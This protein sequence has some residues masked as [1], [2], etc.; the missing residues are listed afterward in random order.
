MPSLSK[1]TILLLLTLCNNYLIS[2]NFIEV[3]SHLGVDHHFGQGYASGGISLVDFNNDGW[4]DITLGTEDGQPISFYTNNGNNSFSQ[5]GFNIP[6]SSHQRHLVWVD[7]DN[8]Q[9][10]DLFVCNHLKPNK[11]YINDG[12][13]NFS[14]QTSSSGIL[15][16]NDDTYMATFGDLDND[17]LLDLYISNHWHAD[18]RVYKNLGNNQFS[19]ISHLSGINNSGSLL[20]ATAFFDFD[21]DGDLDVYK[22]ND[23][24]FRNEMYRNEGNFLFTD[25]SG[26][27]GV[28]IQVDAMGAAIGDLDNDGFSDIY[29]ANSDRTQA[30]GNLLPGNNL[31]KN[32]FPDPF[33]NISNGSGTDYLAWCWGGSW[34]DFD[35][36]GFLDIYVSNSNNGSPNGNKKNVLFF[37]NGDATFTA[38]SSGHMSS[39]DDISYATGTIDLN[40][41]GL[42]DI[43]VMNHDTVKTKIWNNNISNSNNYLKLEL[44]GLQ[45]NHKGVGSWIEVYTP[46][47]THYRYTHCGIGFQSQE[48]YNNHIG[49]G[50]VTTIDSV[51]VRW[52]SGIVDR[53]PSPSINQSI[54]LI[55]GTYRVDSIP[56]GRNTQFPTDSLV[57]L[58]NSI[59]RNWMEILLEAI[60][61]DYARPTVHARNL[62]H[63]S[64]LMYDVWA[65]YQNTSWTYFLGK[66]IDGYTCPFAGLP[67]QST[68]NGEREM[69]ISFA[70]YRL[71]KHRFL[72]SPNAGIMNYHF[73]N[74]MSILGYNIHDTSLDYTSGNPAA[75]GNYIADQIILF[76]LQDGSNES[77]DYTNLYYSPVNDSMIIYNPGNPN[78]TDLNRWQ[79]LTLDSFVDQSGNLIPFDTPEFLSPEWGNV[80]PFS[81]L[82]SDLDIYSRSGDYYSVFYDNIG[83]PQHDMAGG[84]STADYRWGFELVSIWASHLDSADTTSWDIS[85]ASIGNVQSL[86]TNY[87]QYPNFY[88]LYDGGD[89]G[90]GHSHNPA[91]GSAYSSNIIKRADYARVLAEFWADGPDSET[92]PGHWFTLLNYVSD[93]PLLEKKYKGAG[94]LLSDLEWDVKSYFTLGGAM[95]DAAITAWSIKGW[96]DYIRPVS[97]IRAM[98]ELGQSTDSNLPNYHS[99]GISLHN[100]LVELV[101]PND[102]LA[103]DPSNINKIKLYTWRGPDYINDPLIDEAG[104]GWI[105]A[106]N[107]WPYQRPSFVTPPFAGYVSGHSTFSRAAAEVMT[108]LTGDAFFPGGMGEFLAEKNEF[109]VFEEGPSTD[110]T[111]QWATYRDASDQ[112]SLSRIWGGIHPPADDIPGRIIGE[113]VGIQSFNL[114]ELYIN[115][116]CPQSIIIN[117]NPIP[118]SYYN[119][120]DINSAG[121]VTHDPNVTMD[122]RDYIQLNPGFETMLGSKMMLKIKGCPE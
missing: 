118:N 39:D 107:W 77:N 97:A 85:P 9:D 23:K 80:I 38:Q 89:T 92:P 31:L 65:A 45:S 5:I 17:G 70:M 100:G 90:I 69:A 30:Q 8:D 2:Q 76:G 57:N 26:L 24:N 21:K 82:E 101:K 74:F 104:V 87:S 34:T 111:L 25:V 47:D 54:S 75:L 36:D 91:T 93:H 108:L 46:I 13:F 12:N 20:F 58:N 79:P 98:A 94:S 60:R 56:P 112:C 73:D 19:D 71:L 119:A 117:D 106:E 22:S 68:V 110:V 50:A 1:K 83:P 40:N 84:G 86:P 33:S 109:L 95:H 35:N 14:D 48:G 78:I 67:S 122:A 121:K 6:D 53:I 28:D 49:L 15:L 32:M 42:M 52:S 16:G 99:G 105:L 63:A 44:T 43:L 29:I 11:L 18:S 64:V 37:N 120:S 41:D 4:Q 102:P 96:Y 51:R 88:N 81:L 114:A 7:T 115:G 55:E 59:A 66:T 61:T 113:K 3:S 10:L 103:Q 116:I 62:F 72:H 27:Y